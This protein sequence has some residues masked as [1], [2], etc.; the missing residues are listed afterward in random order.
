MKIF[1][2]IRLVILFY[3][4]SFSSFSFAQ[5]TFM[6]RS[7]VSNLDTRKDY[8]KELLKLALDLTIKEYGPYQLVASGA[9]TAN[10]ARQVSKNHPELNFFVKAS[11]RTNILDEMGSVPF[12]IDRGIV[13]YRVFFTSAKATEKLK[14]V[15]TLDDLK[16]LLIGQGI[17]WL[18]T[19][20]LTHHGFNVYTGSSYEGLFKMVA[21][22]R[23]DLFA[24]GTNELFSE[25]NSRNHIKG[26]MYD[27][28]VSLYYPLPRYFFTAK[29]NTESIKRIHKGLIAAYKNGSFVK[30][31][32][33]RYKESIDFVNLKNRKIF[34]ME[35]PFLKG[36]DKTYEQ[37][38]YDPL[39]EE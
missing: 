15:E 23:I 31:W 24:R 39:Q 9:M 28:S 8:E 7:G 29:E 36:I 22:G 32:R 33:E 2:Q 12:P 13:G 14:R 18:D 20:I 1:C 6:Y 34:K 16:N 26:L 17:G 30:L 21:L 4:I 5:D 38:I 10:R 35:N 11:V 19:E 37:Y 3:A 25:Y 27:K